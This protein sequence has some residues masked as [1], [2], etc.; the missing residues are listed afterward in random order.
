MSRMMAVGAGVEPNQ[1]YSWPSQRDLQPFAGADRRRPHH[2]HSPNS[3][4]LRTWQSR[5]QKPE[6]KTPHVTSLL[7]GRPMRR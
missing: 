6:Q 1:G 5:L 7:D 3:S 2:F 4:A